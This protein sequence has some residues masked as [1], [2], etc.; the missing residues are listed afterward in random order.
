MV[1]ITRIVVAAIAVLPSAVVSQNR[2]S[3]YV[4]FR[5]GRRSKTAKALAAGSLLMAA[6]VSKATKAASKSGKASSMKPRC[7]D[8][9]PSLPSKSSKVAAGKSGKSGGYLTVSTTTKASKSSGSDDECDCDGSAWSGKAGK[10]KAGKS[11]RILSSKCSTPIQLNRVVAIDDVKGIGPEHFAT[12]VV[13]EVLQNDEAVPSGQP[14]IVTNVTATSSSGAGMC[15]VTEGRNA[16]VFTPVDPTFAGTASCEYEACLDDGFETN[17]DFAT[18]TVHFEPLIVPIPL[19]TP[20]SFYQYVS[21]TSGHTCLN[22][23]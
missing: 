14:L 9:S 4:L 23:S 19:D 17:C 3:P 20:V 11:G 12:G 10:S 7:F 18:V 22:Y 8:A 13:I 15:A 5:Q 16:V 2:N 1:A 21:C 6:R